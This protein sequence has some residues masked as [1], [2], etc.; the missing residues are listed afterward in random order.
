MIEAA[1]ARIRELG[2]LDDA[3]YARRRA[4]LM[5]ERGYGDYAIKVLLDGLGLPERLALDALSALPAELTERTR[6]RKVIEKKNDLPRV[7]LVRFLAGR[8]FPIDLIL[9]ITGG[10]DT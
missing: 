5:A 2:Y 1:I 8:G 4:L 6:L 3:E 9:D 7:K 10:V